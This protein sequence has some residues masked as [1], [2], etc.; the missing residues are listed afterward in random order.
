MSAISDSNVNKERGHMIFGV[1]QC[2]VPQH[3]AMVVWQKARRCKAVQTGEK[4]RTHS[5]DFKEAGGRR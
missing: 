5:V 2:G 3:K 1:R 4:A